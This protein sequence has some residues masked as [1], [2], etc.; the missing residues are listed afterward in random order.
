MSTLQH[1]NSVI[2]HFWP[3]YQRRFP[4]FEKP[5]IVP[6]ET[7]RGMAPVYMRRNIDQDPTS[8]YMFVR[9]NPMNGDTS[10]ERMK[11]LVDDLFYEKLGMPSSYE[12]QE[13][14][15]REEAI[16]KEVLPA[17]NDAEYR[18]YY[19]EQMAAAEA[20][21]AEKRRKER[22]DA[23]GFDPDDPDIIDV[24]IGDDGVAAPVSDRRA[25][26]QAQTT[27]VAMPKQIWYAV[28]FHCPAGGMLGYNGGGAGG[29]LGGARGGRRFLRE[30]DTGAPVSD[31]LRAYEWAKTTTQGSTS[32]VAG[33]EA[34]AKAKAADDA[35][36]RNAAIHRDFNLYIFKY[37]G[38]RTTWIE[39]E[40][41]R[42]GNFNITW[43]NITDALSQDWARRYQTVQ[44]TVV[45]ID[46]LK[47]MTTV[48]EEDGE[49]N[50]EKMMKEFVDLVG[51]R[52]SVNH[53]DDPNGEDADLKKSG[54]KTVGCHAEP[55]DYDGSRLGYG[56]A[57][58][59][60]R[61]FKIKEDDV[62]ED[63]YR[64]PKNQPHNL[65]RVDEKDEDEENAGAE[66]ESEELNESMI[67]FC[68]RLI[69]G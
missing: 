23:L 10:R 48:A 38:G 54:L 31:I 29:R 22:A 55:D 24:E 7:L 59:G 4:A 45:T 49:S 47:K 1:I 21:A 67:R 13:G 35:N 2:D 5:Q 28:D 16:D 26:G 50:P 18:R 9:A 37:G 20:Q 40:A 12:A 41:S 58:V 15:T 53:I 68:D 43:S 42:P 34:I 39:E 61:T 44:A 62:E 8:F 3:E 52:M 30:A 56:R 69:R 33:L 46:E 51:G 64:R 27:A 14:Y 25:V 19:D 11:E 36:A 32:L 65:H 57:K 66:D 17:A 6:A 60:D 63:E